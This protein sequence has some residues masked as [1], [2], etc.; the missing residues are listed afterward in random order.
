[1]GKG[2][3]KKVLKLTSAKVK[4]II[5][6]KSNNISSKIISIEIRVSIRT[7]NRIWGHWMKNKEALAPDKFG[8]PKTSSSEADKRLILGI[9]EEQNSGTKASRNRNRAQIWQYH[10]TPFFRFFLKMVWLVG[11]EKEETQ[12][13]IYQILTKAQLFCGSP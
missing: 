13:A 9:Y 4:Y 7:V 2:R 6:A 11:Q 12:E 1:M 5:R 8:R 3:R 10:T